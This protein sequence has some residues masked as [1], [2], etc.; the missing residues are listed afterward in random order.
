MC[1]GLPAGGFLRHRGLIL[2]A[3]GGAVAEAGLLTLI[4]PGARPVAPQA[5]ALP[6]L[7]AYHDLRWLFAD[8]QSWPGFVA[9]VVVTLLARSAVDTVLLRLAWPRG[10]RAPSASRSFWSSLAL[11]ALAWLLLSPAVTL[12]FGA[13]VLPFSWPFLAA[14]PIMAGTAIALS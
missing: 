6:V 5:T 3:A 2:A 4:A 12:V 14:L 7:A 8:G 1:V 10:L 11:T 13:A 9:T